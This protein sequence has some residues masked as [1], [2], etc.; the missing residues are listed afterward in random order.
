MF[1]S[2]LRKR[3]RQKLLAQPFSAAWLGYL[4]QNVSHYRYLTAGE[5]ARLRDD[6]RIFIAE[7][8]WERVGGLEL[9]DEMKVPIAAQAGLLVLNIEHNYLSRVIT[10]LIYPHGYKK[11]A[12]VAAIA[13][14]IA[15]HATVA[16][17][18]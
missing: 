9:T 10:I 6:L 15:L 5:Q 18:G 11:V 1:F 7:K 4:E 14:D 8:S 3:R 12:P 2:W 13:P 16:D 17:E